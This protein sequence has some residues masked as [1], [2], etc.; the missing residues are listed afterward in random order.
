MC[1]GLPLR[2]FGGDGL[3]DVQDVIKILGNDEYAKK[4]VELLLKYSK[5]G[6][7]PGNEVDSELLLFFDYFKLALPLNAINNSLSWNLRLIQADKL[8][9]PYVVRFFFDQLKRGEAD[10]REVIKNYFK[11][12]GES[13]PEDFVYI[14]KEMVKVSKNLIICA[15]DVVE[16]S[17]RWNRD[18][19]VVIAE[20]KGAG[21]I[22]PFMGCGKIG[23][24]GA[25][26]YEVNR[27][28]A[29]LVLNDLNYPY[30][31]S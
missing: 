6:F 27:F 5:E 11:S 9:I 13:K 14:Y 12:I 16:I 23:K 7:I 22:S 24:A 15:K 19:G 28:F 29:N 21:L 3:M 10:W 8:E 17:M 18:G 4:A 30:E 20:M 25:P 1:K 2:R 26:L 31:T